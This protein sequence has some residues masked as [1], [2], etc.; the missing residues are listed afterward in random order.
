MTDVTTSEAV[1]TGLQLVAA[2]A[3]D[4]PQ[5]QIRSLARLIDVSALHRSFARVE[6]KSAVGV[7]GVTKTGY[8]EALEENL[9]DLHERLRAGRYRH[10]PILRV[11]IPKGDG[12]TRPIGISCVEDKVV[13]GALKEVLEAVYEQDF[14]DCSFGFRPGRSAHD[15][16]RELN[17]EVRDNGIRFILEADIESFFDC[18]DRKA[19]MEM[20]RGRIADKSLMRLIG[21]C[22]H[23]GV[24]DGVELTR[25]EEGTAQGSVLSP[26][27]GNIYLHHVLDTWLEHE[28]KPRLKGHC[29]LIR[30]ADDFVIGFSDGE[31]AERVMK[32]LPKRM[33]RFGLRLH[34]DKTRL[35]P[36]EPPKDGGGKGS[37]TFDF[38]GF[39]AFWKRTRRG[40]WRLAY[41]T[42]RG[43]LQRSCRTIADLCRRQRHWPLEEQ[44]DAL[45]RRMRGHINYF[46]VSG[47]GD[48]VTTFTFI[49]VDTWR[50]WLR[51]RSQKTKLTWENFGKMLDIY[52]L[53]R[54]K[55]VVDIWT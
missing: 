7:D 32:V 45:A 41:K 39:T 13:Q 44:R 29:C 25:P 36:F 47:N 16:L 2:I 3:R 23:V 48:A 17:R 42:R 31:D 38:L 52:R 12:K 8:G 6:N 40:N 5:K 9:R 53:P 35:F 34:P 18:I 54:P 1:L 19:L 11:R 4:D 46:G 43:G 49:V 15:A 27:L 55:I 26:L 37:G 21:K 30:Y 50:K 33:G 24:L 28:I 10:Q 20:I 51:R 22:L 14:L